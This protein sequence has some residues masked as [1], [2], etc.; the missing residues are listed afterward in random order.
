MSRVLARTPTYELYR[1][2]TFWPLYAAV[3]TILLW[4][5]CLY[6][7]SWGPLLLYSGRNICFQIS[8]NNS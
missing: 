3:F 4:L 5:H 8:W 6:F 7:R 2:Q 1:K